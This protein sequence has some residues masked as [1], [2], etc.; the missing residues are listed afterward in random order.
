VTGPAGPVRTRTGYHHGDLR[1]ALLEAAEALLR[2]EGLAGLTLRACARRAGV[3]HAAPKHHF[4][5]VS[6]LLSEVAARGFE[7][8]T[9]ALET[10]AEGAGPD[11]G[12]RFSAA[13]RTYVTFAR[14]HPAHFRLMFRSDALDVCHGTLAA[15]SART[16]AELTGN[17][18]R[19]RGEPDVAPENL[20]DRVQDDALMED[21]L[22]GWSYVHGYT[23]LLLEGQLSAFAG[24]EQL[25]DFIERTIG[26]TSRRLSGLLGE[27]GEDGAW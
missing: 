24:E 4:A 19:L 14:Q 18:T 25:D 26:A 13:A 15:A 21:V 1:E 5:D 6:T 7:R 20:A 23:Q 17:I 2:E 12:R 9:A 3:S 8:L 27:R 11:P 10:A 16:F 22:L